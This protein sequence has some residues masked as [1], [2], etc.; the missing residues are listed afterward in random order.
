MS[1][2]PNH[3]K[4]L[5]IDDNKSMQQIYAVSLN[6]LGFQSIKTANNGAEALAMMEAERADFDLIFCDLCIVPENGFKFIR[7]VRSTSSGFDPKVPIIVVGSPGE[8]EH[9]KEA[10]DAGASEF[11]AKP[12]TVQNLFKR[13]DAALDRPGP[14]QGT[15]KE[16]QQLY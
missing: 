7:T 11:L 3:L 2:D 4:I 15:V 12:V 8:A 10:R 16:D 1:F 6:S 9:I 14:L 5:C 13:I